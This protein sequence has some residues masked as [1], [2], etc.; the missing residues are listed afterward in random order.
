[1]PRFTWARKGEILEISDSS[2]AIAKHIKLKT[3]NPREMV[4][5][6]DKKRLLVMT[7][8]FSGI[9]IVDLQKAEV[10]DS[11]QMSTP[12]TRLRPTSMAVDPTGRFVYTMAATHTKKIDRW[13]IG[14]DK[15][16]VIDLT[17]RKIVRSELFPKDKKPNS[18]GMSFRV[19]P[20]GKSLYL[21]GESVLIFNTDTLKLEKENQPAEADLSRYVT[22]KLCSRN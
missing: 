16:A 20:D 6:P 17:Q 14:E 13:E 19:S 15:L 12:T 8:D 2:Y 22:R 7:S 5:M 9:E 1:M 21:F 18:F 4:L 11:W 10:V 3:G